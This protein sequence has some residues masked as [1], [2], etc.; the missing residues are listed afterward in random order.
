MAQE[1]ETVTVQVGDDSN[2]LT[3][4]VALTDALSQGDESAADVVGD[5]ALLGLAQQ[6]H[7][8]VHHSHEDVG[9]ELAEAEEIVLEEFERRFGRSFAEMTGHSH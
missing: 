6:A 1:T 9:E 8:L 5:I 4:P 7:G 2:E 3:V